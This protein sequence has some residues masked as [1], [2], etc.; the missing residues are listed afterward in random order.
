[1]WK[2]RCGVRCQSFESGGAEYCTG[3]LT[4]ANIDHRLD[5]VDRIAV[6][7]ENGRDSNVLPASPDGLALGQQYLIRLVN[8]GHA[9]LVGGRI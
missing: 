7:S 8:I 2:S 9:Q 5:L 4:S 3:L 1:M 6:T